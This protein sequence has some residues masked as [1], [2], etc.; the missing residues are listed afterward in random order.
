MNW[1]LEFYLIS[2]AICLIIAI[3]VMVA[4]HVIIKRVD[5]SNGKNLSKISLVERLCFI[6]PFLIPIL[7]IIVAVAFCTM[8]VM[9]T[10]ISKVRE[11]V[12]K[13]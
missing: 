13:Q 8:V 1:F 4:L 5:E 9:L 3:L 11:I 10:I 6:T 7:N 12:N 2:T